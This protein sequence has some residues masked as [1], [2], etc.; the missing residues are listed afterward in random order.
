MLLLQRWALMYI[1]N[2]LQR[3]ALA[4]A[5]IHLVVGMCCSCA[6][7]FSSR[8]RCCDSPTTRCFSWAITYRIIC[9]SHQSQP[10]LQTALP[11]CRVY[12]C[13]SA[14]RRQSADCLKHCRPFTHCINGHIS[15]IDT[16]SSPH[17]RFTGEGCRACDRLAGVLLRVLVTETD[18]SCSSATQHRERTR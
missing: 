15:S 16:S 3:W 5:R 11:S 1:I 8:S 18:V 14:S 7:L 13:R 9:T 6:W 12:G 17:R 10:L 4:R 2:S